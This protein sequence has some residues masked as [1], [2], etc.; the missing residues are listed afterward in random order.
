L[1]TLL[2]IILVSLGS[3]CIGVLTNQWLG[4]GIRWNVLV[5]SLPRV[6]QQPALKYISTDSAYVL[7]LEQT[8]IFLDIRS[9][10]D[11]ALDHIPGSRSVPFLEM[12][13]QP[14]RSEIVNPDTTIVCYGFDPEKSK[15]KQAADLLIRKGFSQVLILQGGFAEWIERGYP[16]ERVDGS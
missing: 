14:G 6:F 7:F 10:E 11:Y 3:L 16:V 2:R 8:G 1:R 9:P 12:L 5:F 15:V 4:H 13:R